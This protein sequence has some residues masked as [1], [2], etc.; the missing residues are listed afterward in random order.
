MNKL[1]YVSHSLFFISSTCIKINY[2]SDVFVL[3]KSL[4]EPTFHISTQYNQAY[5]CQL[6]NIIYTYDCFI[7]L[8]KYPIYQQQLHW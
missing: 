3:K 7:F 2:I 1:N 8:N 5:K 6:Q 4:F